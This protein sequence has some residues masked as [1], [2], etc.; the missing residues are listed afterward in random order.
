MSVYSFQSHCVALAM[1]KTASLSF[2]IQNLLESDLVPY[3]SLAWKSVCK[4]NCGVLDLSYT[5]A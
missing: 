5:A 4:M 1:T 2:H 3:G